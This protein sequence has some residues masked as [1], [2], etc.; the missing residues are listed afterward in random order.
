METEMKHEGRS[1]L[2]PAS[3]GGDTAQAGFEFQTGF[4]V[5]RTAEWISYEGF[6]EFIQEG[7]SDVEASFF[8]PGQGY[9]KELCQVKSYRLIA[10]EFWSEIRGFQRIDQ[11][12]PGT[13][14]WFT[15]VSQGLAK[16]LIPLAKDLRRIRDPYRFYE[17]GNAILE[18]SYLEYVK[19]VEGCGGTEEEAHF[20]FDKVL[21]EC[22][23]GDAC[24]F[25]GL[26]Q[27]RLLQWQPEY[28]D[29]PAR[30]LDG[31]YQD[32]ASLVRSRIA[33]PIARN[34]LEQIVQSR[35]PHTSR[36][37]VRPVSIH[38]AG[39]EESSPCTSVELNWID[40]FGGTSRTFPP[41]EEW[42]SRLVS[43]LVDTRDWITRHRNSR[44]IH[45]TGERRLSASLAIGSVFAAVSGFTIELEY[46]G[47]L[48]CT[49]VKPLQS[50]LTYDLEIHQPTGTGNELVVSIGILRDIRCEVEAYGKSGPLASVP[51]LHIVGN[52]QI[53]CPEHANV[54]VR[55]IKDAICQALVVTGASC[56]HLFYAG[57]SHVALFLGH[58]LNATATVKCY[59][60][61]SA[62]SYVQ[63]CTLHTS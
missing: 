52:A 13:Y 9:V 21:I 11:G 62:N 30:C 10:S 3:T 60:R 56:I 2:E 14:G 22:T 12:A 41:A 17:S 19:R 51:A 26:F 25:P 6:T 46:R 38:T 44:C 16:E 58:R 43:Q 50:G 45:L 39:K 47:E 24:T 29:L 23:Y 59:E 4:I 8:A 27:D 18:H 32:I 28:G 48:W 40:F 33:K 15:L 20:L 57:P 37:T 7:I 61:V 5:Y 1:L 42:D 63:T 34:E 35:V 31:I 53:T 49:G 55:G 54:A 36:P